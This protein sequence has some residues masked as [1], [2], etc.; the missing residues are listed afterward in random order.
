MSSG[1]FKNVTNK[2]FVY[3]SYIE[4]KYKEDWPLNNLQG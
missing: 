1:N 2:V 3:K 4:Y